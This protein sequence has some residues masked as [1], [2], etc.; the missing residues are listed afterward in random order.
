M[1]AT[2][3]KRMAGASLLA[4]A[5]ALPA[6]AQVM[7][8]SNN[9]A[10]KITQSIAFGSDTIEISYTSITW[11]G[12]Q[13][14]TQLADESTRAATRARINASAEKKPMGALKC[15]SAIVVGTQKV[16]AGSYKLE[17][18]LDEACKWQLVLVGETGT[19]TCPLDLKE[20]TEESKRLRVG[21][22]A[23]E[24]DFTAELVVGFGKS[25]GILPVTLDKKAS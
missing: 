13:W 7:G 3:L 19:V 23:G 20:G 6:V 11:G 9:N 12:G 5:V 18:L 21:V 2:M 25:R 14:A 17:F 22:R 1:N 16:A 15:S 24:K 8:S 10:P 4:L